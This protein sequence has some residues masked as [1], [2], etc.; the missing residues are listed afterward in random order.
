MKEK[1]R[2]KNNNKKRGRGHTENSKEWDLLKHPQLH[3]TRKGEKK[4]SQITKQCSEG[5][6]MYPGVKKRIAAPMDSCVG[7]LWVVCICM[8]TW[9]ATQ[10]W[11][12]HARI[13]SLVCLTLCVSCVP[14]QNGTHARYLPPLVQRPANAASGQGGGRWTPFWVA[15]GQGGGRWTPGG[16]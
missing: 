10:L 9:Y 7:G 15:S 13:R 2:E 12:I 6:L 5:I 11:V 8:H 3:T 16:L 1:N 14:T 4:W